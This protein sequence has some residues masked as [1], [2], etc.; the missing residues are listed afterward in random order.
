MFETERYNEI[1]FDNNPKKMSTS[2]PLL[3]EEVKKG[4]S[5]NKK[6][7]KSKFYL[8]PSKENS[9]QSIVLRDIDKIEKF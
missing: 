7:T 9:V 6:S 3:Q 4:K 8:K 1:N 5:F 2:V